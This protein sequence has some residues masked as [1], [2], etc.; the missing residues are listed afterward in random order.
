MRRLNRNVLLSKYNLASFPAEGDDYIGRS[1][2]V[3]FPP[4]N[5]T[6]SFN[7][8]I[9]SDIIF[10]PDGI[11]SLRLEAPQEMDGQCKDVQLGT[12]DRANV[13]IVNDER[14]CSDNVLRACVHR[15]ID[16]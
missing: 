8:P 7:I 13:T 15:Y 6:A 10:E 9:V 3:T 12:P 14:M 2:M 5:T 4:G 11:F 16:S 1:F